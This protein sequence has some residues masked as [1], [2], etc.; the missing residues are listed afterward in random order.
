[1]S[2]GRPWDRTACLGWDR[3]QGGFVGGRAGRSTVVVATTSCTVQLCYICSVCCHGDGFSHAFGAFQKPF[4]PHRIHSINC[5]L[6]SVYFCLYLCVCVC[7]CVCVFV[8]QY[9]TD[10]NE[11]IWTQEMCDGIDITFT[12]STPP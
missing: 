11:G 6:Q 4:F 7:V 5:T 8:C 9:I 3:L 12:V 10:L 1:V 2:S